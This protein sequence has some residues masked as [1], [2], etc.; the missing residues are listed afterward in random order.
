MVQ[1]TPVAM[2]LLDPGAR[3]VYANLA[4]R[5]LLD[6]GGRMEGLSLDHVLARAPLRRHGWP[7]SERVT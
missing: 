2:L 5:R 3:A 1:N 4:A 6:D 7:A